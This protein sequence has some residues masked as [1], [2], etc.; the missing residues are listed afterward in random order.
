MNA[1]PYDALTHN[2]CGNTR[3]CKLNDRQAG[4]ITPRHATTLYS[5]RAQ[6]RALNSFHPKDVTVIK[7]SISYY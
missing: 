5:A 6:K 7:C 2:L 4:V 1:V 3:C